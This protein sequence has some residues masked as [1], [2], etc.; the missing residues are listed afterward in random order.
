MSTYFCV[1]ELPDSQIEIDENM[2]PPIDS[3]PAVGTPFSQELLYAFQMRIDTIMENQALLNAMYLDPRY[4]CL[5]S[6]SQKEKTVKS[7]KTLFSRLQSNLSP[8][9]L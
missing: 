6:S 3:N 2:L 1:G 9:K 8:F 5:L 7:L 4:N